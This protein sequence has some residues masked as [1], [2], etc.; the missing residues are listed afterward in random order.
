MGRIANVTNGAVSGKVGPVVYYEMKG[1]AYV[2]AAMM[3]RAKGS[4]SAE[5]TG[6]RKKVSQVAAIWRQLDKNPVKEIWARAAEQMS[7]YN[8]FLKTNLPAFK[9]EEMQADPEFFHLTAGALPLP[10]HLNAEVLEGNTTK[11][12][13]SWKDDSGYQLSQAEDELMVIFAHDGKFTHPVATGAHRSQEK[14]LIQVPAEI[15][16]LQGIH[17]FF[18]A[19]KRGIY[20]ADQ[21]FG[22]ER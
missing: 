19:A 12:Q 7:A 20:S 17:L 21:F 16:N 3:P 18:A 13:V 14:A 5:Q 4:W 1:K 9:G 2:R 11:W 10:H 22:V 6:V 8:L 15:K